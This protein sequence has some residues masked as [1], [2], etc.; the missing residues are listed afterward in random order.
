MT[1]DCV[2][3]IGGFRVVPDYD[4]KSAPSD[5]AALILIGE[6]TWRNENAQQVKVRVEDCY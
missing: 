3:S 5:Y 1:K 6:M 4:V 2:C